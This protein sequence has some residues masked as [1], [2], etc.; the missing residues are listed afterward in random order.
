MMKSVKRELIASYFTP[1]SNHSPKAMNEPVVPPAADISISAFFGVDLNAAF[2]IIYA[3]C[4]A[5]I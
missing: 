3:C 2:V 1:V 4:S 5:I